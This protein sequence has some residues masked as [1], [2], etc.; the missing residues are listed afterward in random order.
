MTRGGYKSAHHERRPSFP[1]AKEQ[2]IAA[3]RL[4]RS[5]ECPHGPCPR[6]V[7]GRRLEVGPHRSLRNVTE[8]NH[9]PQGCRDLTPVPL[10]RSEEVALRRLQ[11]FLHY[12]MIGRWRIAWEILCDS[13]RR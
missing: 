5:P 12:A 11:A 3:L 9:S 8:P 1:L 7:R 6:L 13:E 2:T 4:L 10:Q